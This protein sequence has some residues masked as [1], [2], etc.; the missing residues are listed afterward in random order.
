MRAGQ[1]MAR[2]SW[3][4]GGISVIT[5]Y[6]SSMKSP[7]IGLAEVLPDITP[8]TYKDVLKRVANMEHGAHKVA[9]AYY[10]YDTA[11]RSYE[12]QHAAWLADNPGFSSTTY[13]T[14][15]HMELIA[16]R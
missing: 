15:L 5:G 12:E 3:A 8:D 9:M 10:E 6:I 4:A 1:R 13:A 2:P 7:A 16:M 14:A 11:T